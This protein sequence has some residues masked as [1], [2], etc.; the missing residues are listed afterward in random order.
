M[1]QRHGIKSRVFPAGATAHLVGKATPAPVGEQGYLTPDHVTFGDSSIWIWKCR[2]GETV[3]RAV[4]V[5]R[6]AVKEGRTPKCSPACTGKP[7]AAV[8]Q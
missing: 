6:R 7:A 1:D 2:C 5:V 4:K 3:T 8:S